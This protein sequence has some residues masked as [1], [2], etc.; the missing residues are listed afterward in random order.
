MDTNLDRL[1]AQCAQAIIERVVDNDETQQR[2]SKAQL[3][4]DLDNTLTKALG[5]LQEH[6][7]YAC[8]L[9]LWAKEKDYGKAVSEEMLR[10]I[11]Q[12]DLYHEK[13]AGESVE[14]VLRYISET[15]TADLEKLLLV[16]E[17]LE[18]ALIYGR[19][20]AKARQSETTTS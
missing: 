3:A 19:Y 20:G 15:V 4:A 1:A 16:K 7:V 17:T 18:L 12:M 8:F 5:V 9:Y 10:L 11:E 14:H 13:P 6:G 2:K